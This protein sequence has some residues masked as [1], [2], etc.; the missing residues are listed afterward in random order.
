MKV[1][2]FTNTS[3][4][5]DPKNYS[6]GWLQSLEKVLSK[7]NEYKLFIATRARGK[8]KPGKFFVEQTTYFLVPDNRSIL[9]KRFDIFLNKEPHTYFL[10]KYLSIIDEVKP[11]IIQVFGS[12]MDYGMIC[13]R[14]KVPVLIHIQGILHPC[15]YYLNSVRLSFTQKIRIIN[16]WDLIKGNTYQNVLETF[17][18]RT[19]N[20]FKILSNCPNVLG[21]TNWDR[22]VMSILAPNARYFHGDEIL[23]EQFFKY[24]WSLKEKEK[25]QITSIIS[26]ALYKGHDTISA[27]IKVLKTYGLN[28]KW[29]VIGYDRT[30][31]AYKLFF[32]N[33][34]NE[35]EGLLE[36]HGGLNPDQLI[37][38]LMDSS[39][40]VHPSHIEN[41]SNALCEA[42]ALGM[43]VIAM[44]VGGNSSIIS[45]G[46]DGIITPDNDPF[47]LS[48]VILEL[49][50][51]KTKSAFLGAN[52]RK[53]AFERHNPE[54]I[55][56]ELKKVYLDLV[57]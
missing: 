9:R 50:K 52:A 2:W 10:N 48:G 31:S 12:E 5:L 40:Y 57:K 42:M 17:K 7:T 32:K 8:E 29:N 23:R 38:I 33:Y 51:D 6:G 27:T 18:R 22:R 49:I 55:V 43:P 46:D 37:E 1:L 4:N 15:Y 14:T 24:T 16:L 41:S 36:F 13:G 19:E 26:S 45:H 25:I 53:R 28:F 20:E 11:D 44:D 56:S 21:R 3:V 47:S 35:F 30:S 54:R 34:E 39:L